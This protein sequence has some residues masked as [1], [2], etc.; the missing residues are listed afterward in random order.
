MFRGNSRDT[1]Y[2]DISITGGNYDSEI[3]LKN[4][5]LDPHVHAQSLSC[6][7]LFDPMDC[8]PPGSSVHW[9]LPQAR[10]LEWIAMPS[11][12]DSSLGD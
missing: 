9:I 4:K 7:T 6:L 10:I 1:Y 11:S 5:S 12:R 8:H 3:M 2:S